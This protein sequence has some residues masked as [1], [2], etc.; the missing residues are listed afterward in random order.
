MKMDAVAYFNRGPARAGNSEY[1]SAIQD[2]TKVIDTRAK[3]TFV[4][5][6]GNAPR[7][8]GPR[9]PSYFAIIREAASAFLLAGLRAIVTIYFVTVAAVFVILALPVLPLLRLLPEDDEEDD[10]D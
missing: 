2:C 3:S 9:I 6:R 1:D 7:R 10:D 8:K 4:S 5:S